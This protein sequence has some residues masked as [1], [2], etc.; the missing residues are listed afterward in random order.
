MELG[1]LG[2]LQVRR[3]GAPVSIPGAKPRAVLT[4]LGLHGGSVVSADTLFE[5]LWGEDPPR[6]AAKALQTHISSL[7]RALGDGVVV[8]EGAGWALAECDVDAAR[9]RSAARHG[10]DA[11]AAGDISQAV[12]HFEEALAL[13]RGIPELPDGRPGTSEKTRWNEGH[14]ALIEDRADALLATG[15]AA[16]IIGELETAVSEAPLRERRWAQLMLALYRAGRQGEALAA[17][18]RARTVLA[19]ELGIDPGPELRKLETA[20]VAQDS[21]LDIVVA[22]QLPSVMRAVTFLLTDIEGS[23]ATWEADADAMAVALARHDELAEQVV[24]S[25]GGRLIKTRGEG[26]ATFSV[27]ERPSAAAAAAM[28]LQ[29]AITHEQWG[30][31]APMRIRIALHTG[32][33]ELRDGDYFGRAV[34][35]AARL[36]SLAVGGQILCSGATAELV[37]DSLPDDVVLADLGM[38]QL[39]NLARPEHVFELRLETADDDRPEEVSESPL[40]RPGLP[41]V[42]TGSGPFVG[43]GRELDGLVSAWQTALAGGAHAV[44]IAGEPGVGKTRLAGE[45]SQQAYQQGAVVLYGR[46]D[47]DLGAPYQPF[48]EALRSLVPCLGSSR[49]R[50]TR[51]VEALLPLV[52]ALTDVLPDVAAP[53]RADPDT[54]RYALFDAVVALLETASAASPIVLVLDDLHWAAKPTLLL[55]RHFLRFGDHA[56][57]Q[58]VGTYRS[59]DLDRSHPLAAMLADL[60]RDG[61]S[62]RINLSGLNEDDVSAYVAKAGYDDE[63]LGRALASV[64]GGNPFFLIEALRHVDESGGSWDPS[65]LPQGVREAVSRRLSRL[66]VETNKALAAAAVVGNRFALEF[67]EQVTDQDLVDAFDEACKAGIILEEPGG[68]YRFNHA[69]V[70]QSLLAELPS[71]RR[72]RLH[73][74]IAATLETQPGADDELLAELAHHYFECAWAGNAAK[75]VEYSRRAADQAMARLGYEGAADL[76]DQ[77]L[78]ALEEIDDDLPDRDDQAAELLVAR[79]EA[80]LAAGDVTSAVGAVAQLQSATMHSGRLAAWATCFDGQLSML[81]HPERLDEAETALSAAA[82]KLAELDDA[83][84]EAKAHTVRA[85]CLARLGRIGDCEVALDDALTAARRAR[86]H[87]RVNAVLAGAPL[88]ALWGPNPVPRAGGRCLDVVRLLRITTDSPAVEATS[89]RCQ[90]VLEAFRGRDAAARRM[91][92][93]ARRTVTELGLRHALLEVEQFAGIVELV[94]ADPATAEPHLRKAYKGFRRMGLDADTAETAA[95]LGRACVALDRDAEADELCTESE[96][97]AGHALKPSIAWRTLRSQLLS[98][99]GN[100]EEARRVAQAAIALAERTDGLVDHGDACQSLATV[101]AAAGDSAG[102]RAAAERAANLYER[103]G[104]AALADR[105]RSMLD[106]RVVS[107]PSTPPEA[108]SIELDNE[109]LRVGERVMDAIH[110]QAWD[111]VEELFAPGASIESRRKV[112][113]LTMPSDAARLGVRRELEAGTA[114]IHHVMVAA[115]GERLALSRLITSSADV[116]PGAPYDE[117][118]QLYAIDD[119][120]RVALQIWFDVEDIDAAIAELDALHARFEGE[121]PPARRF[122]NAASRADERVNELFADRRW[123]EID[124]LLADDVRVDD[125]RRGLHREGADHATELANA[126]A[127]ADVGVK[128]MTSRV[129]AIRGQRLVLTRTVFSGRDQRPDAFR[130]EMLRIAEI[131]TDE[132]IV[133]LVAF[134]LDDFDSAIR[135]LDARYLVGEAAGYEHTWSIVAGA[136]AAFNRRELLATTPDWVSIDHRRGAAFADGDMIAYI[137]AA[138]DDSPDT[139]IYVGEVHRLNKVGAVVTHLARG[140]SQEDFDAEWRDVNVLAVEGDMVSRSELFNEGDLDAAI[141]TFDELSP[142][143][144]RLESAASQAVERYLAHFAARDW[145]ALAEVLAKDVAIDDRRRVVNA[146]ARHGRDAEIANLRATADAGFMHITSVVIAARGQRLILTRSAGHDR[147]SEE[148]LSDALA[149]VEISSHNQIAAIVIFDLEDFDAA[150]AE[151]DARFV[152]GEAAAYAH[153]WSVIARG[154]AALNRHE[155]PPTTP[156]CVSIDHRRG[157]AFA[158]GDLIE[159]FRA[160]W[161]LGQDIRTYVEVVHRLSELGA[162]CTHAGH[163]V[164]HEGFDAE[165]HGVDLLTVEGDMVNRCEA[166]DDADLDSALARFDE[167]HPRERRLE[168]AASQVAKR[169]LAHFAARDWDEL[170]KVLADDISNDDRRRVV[171]AGIRHGRDAEL[172]SLRAYA[173]VGVMHMGSVSMA[174]RGARLALVRASGAGGE[175]REFFNELLA[176][177][178]IN[179]HDQISAIVV[180]D[181]DDFEAA[182]AELDSRFLAGEGAANAQTWSVISGSYAAINRHEPPLTTPDCVNIDRRREIAMGV[183]D[184]IASIGAGPDPN[185]DSKVYVEAV[186]RL[187]E[188]GAVVT[189][190]AY[191]TSQ[192]G[193]DAEWRGIAVLTVDGELVNRTEV[194]DEADLDAAIASFDQL[195]RPALRLENTA[196][197]AN[198]RLIAHVS[199]REWDAAAS[200]LA[201]DHYSDDRRRITGAGTRRGRDAD[202]ENFRVVADLGANIAVEVIATRG[203]RLVLTR[204]HVELGDK[205]QPF[206][207]EFFGVVETDLDG[208]IAAV[209][210]LD[211]EDF[212]AAI[213]ELDARYLAGEAAA[214]ARTW[215]AVKDSYD[216]LNRHEIPA[217]TGDFANIDHRRVTPFAPGEVKAYARASWD[218][219]P[220]ASYRIETV[221]RLSDRGAIV[222]HAIRGTSQDGFEAEWREIHLIAVQGDLCNRSELFDEGDLDA[223]LARFDELSRSVPGL[224]NT[225][226]RVFKRLYS[227]VAAGEWHAVTQ[228][229]AENVSV[230]DR[231]RVVNAGILHGRD[232]NIKDAQA[233][234]GVGFTMTMLDVLA[235]RG[236]RI[237]LTGIRV[238]GRDPQA[239]QNDALQIMEIDAEERIARVVVFDL[240]DFDAAIAELDARYLAGE[241]MVH[242]HTWSVIS[243]V[244][245]ALSRR[246]LPSTTTDFV[247]IDHR[248]GTA[249]AAGELMEYLRAGWDVHQEV[250]PYVEAVHRLSNL[251]AVVTHSARLTSREGFEAEWRTIDIM[252]VDGDLIDRAELFDEADLDAA[253]AKFEDLTQPKPRLENAASHVTEH[254]AVHLRARDWDAMAELLADDFCSDDRRGVVGAGIQHGRDAHMADMRTIVDLWITNVSSTIIATRGERLVLMRTHF[255]GSDQGPGAFVTEVFGLVEIDTDERIVA[256]VSFDVDHIDA[257]IAELDARYLAGEAAVYARTWSVVAGAY[258]AFNRHELPAAD[259]VTVDNRRATPFSSSTMTA[260]LRA[261]WDLTPDLSIH[262]ET[263]HRLNTF[264]AVITHTGSGTSPEGFDAEWRAI[265]ILTVDGERITRCEIFDDDDDFEAALARFDELSRT[266]LQLR[267]AATRAY[268]R[269]QAQFAARDWDGLAGALAD[270]VFRDDRRRLVGAELRTGRDA[271]VAEFSAL[272]EIGVKRMT[273][274]TVAVRGGRLLLS[275]SRALGRDPRADAFRTDVLSILDLDADERI[276]AILTFDPDDL[277]AAI[278]ELDARYLAGEAAPYST[279]WSAV[280]QGY[281]ALNRHELPLM[282]PDVVT[283]DHRRGRGFAPGDLSAYLDASWELMPESTLYIA[284]VNRLNDIG[285]VVTHVVHG[286]TAEGFEAV[287]REITVLKAAGDRMSRC[288]MF[289]EEDFDAAIA[290]FNEFGPPARRLENTASQVDKRFQAC[291]GAQDWDVMAEMLSAGFSIEDRRRVVN[292]GNLHGRDAELG[293]HAYAAA[294]TQNVES[295]VIATRG[296]RVT[297]NHYR[298]SGGDQSPDAFSVEMLAVVEIDADERMAAVVVFDADDLDAALE[299]LENRYLAGEAAAHARTWT[300]IAKSFA[301]IGRQELPA[302]SPGTAFVDHRRSAAFGATD[303]SAY[304]R[305]GWDPGQNIRPHV[306]AVHRLTDLGAVYSY[307]AHGISHE[308]FDAAWQGVGLTTVDGDIVNRCEFF[309]ED[310]LAAA[311]ATFDQLGRPAPLL[312]NTA[313]RTVDRVN[314]YFAARDWAAL[315]TMMANDVVD[316][317]RRRIANA[318]I[319]QG[320]DAIV[321]GVQTAAGLGAQHITSTAIAIRGDRLAL[322]R[323]R[324]SG[325]DQGPEAFYAEALGVVEV[326]GDERVVAHVGFDLEDIDAALEELENRYLAGQAAAHAHTWSLIAGGNAAANRNETLPMTPDASMIDHRLRTTL[327]ADGLNA[328]VR[329]SRDLTPDLYTLIESVHRLSDFGVVVTHASRGTSQDDFEA[330]WRQITL[331][332]VEGDLCNRCEIFD[333]ADLDAALAR[334]DELDRTARTLENAASQV[335]KSFLAHFAAGD[336][337]AMAEILADDFFNDDRRQVVS[338]EVL[339]GR[340]AQM[341]NMRA[342]AELL[343][344]DVTSTVIA[345]RAAR[346]ALVRL[347]FS[348]RSHAPNAFQIEVL[349]V[350]GIDTEDRIA[351]F[352]VFDVDDIH[353]AF[354]ELDAR[355]LAGEASA[356]AQTWSAISQMCAAINRREVFATTDE[357]VDID[358]RSLAA[359]GSGDLKAYIGAAL[360]DGDYRIHIESVQL[361]SDLGAVVGLVS[362]GT[363][364]GGFEGE[365]RMTDIF[366]VEGDVISRCEIYDDADLD[367]ALARFEELQPQA[368]RLEH[369]VQERFLAHFAARDWD[370]MG[371]DFADDYYC[372]D[373]RRVVNAGVRHGRDAAFE[374]LRVAADIGLITNIT[375]E[376]IATRGE[377]LFLG[378]TRW[379]GP[380][381]RPEDFNT[382]IVNVIE[383]DAEE[384]IAAQ[385]LFDSND[386]GSAVEELDARYLAGEA[387]GHHKIWSLIAHAFAAIN[388]HELP[389]LTSNW[390]NIDHRRGAAFATGDMTAY[391]RD[392]WEDAPD[393]HVYVEAVHCLTDFGA[394]V[395]QAAHGT[396]RHGFEA[397][398]RE[399]A[400]FTFDGDLLSRCELFDEKDLDAA[401]AR[402]EELRPR[403]VQLENAATRTVEQFFAH[404]AVC[405]WDAMAELLADDVSADDRRPVVNAGIRRGRDAEMA[406]WRAT[407]DLWTI[408]VRSA[409]ATR[410]ERLALVRF[411]FTNKDDG[412]EAFSVA[413]LAVVGINDSN[414]ISEIVVIEADDADG[415]FAELDVRY[416]AGEAAVHA[417]TWSV[418]TRAFAGLNQHQLPS[419][420]PGWVNID[421][422]STQRVEADDLTALIRATW[423]VVP[424]GRVYIEAVHRLNDVGLAITYI[425]RGTSQ[426]GFD[427]EWRAVNISTVDGDMISRSEIFDE[428]D[429]DAALARFDELHPPT[430]RLENA[431]TQVDQRFWSHFLARNWDAMEQL[432]ADDISTEDRRRVM[433]A[434]VRHGRAGYMAEMRA[435][436]ELGTENIAATVVAIRGA[437]LALIRIRGSNNAAGVGELSVEVLNIVELD[438]E[439]RIAAKVGFDVDKIDAAFAELD[440]RYIAGEARAHARTWSVISRFNDA[441]NRHEIPATD[442]VTVDHRRLIKADASDQSALV[443]ELWNATPDLRINIETVHRLSDF[444]G[445]VTR[446]LQGTTREGFYAEWRMIQLLTV[447]GD[448]IS[449]S[450]LFDETDLDAAL[451][452]F[453]ELHPQAR[454]VENAASRVY[455]RFQAHFATRDWHAIAD[456]LTADLYSDDRRFVVGGG[457]RPGRDALIEDLRAVADVDITNATADV[458]ATRGGRLALLR[459]QFSRGHAEPDPFHVDFLQLVEINAEDR[460]TA[461]IAFDANDIDA[462]F[463]ELD[464]RYLAGEA[465]PHA[466]TWTAI[467]Q[468]QAAYNRHELPPTTADLVNID[469]RRG[470]A[471]ATGDTIPWL[472]ATYDVAPNVKGHLEAVHRLG[473]LG[474]VVTEVVTGTS[475]AGFAFEWREVAVFVF[476]GDKIC[477]FELFDETDLDAA[478]ARFD[479]LHSHP[480]RL[481]NAASQVADRY[482]KYFGARD[483]AALAET[484][485]EDV[486]SSDRR[487]VINAG[488]LRG[489][490][491]HLANMRAVAEVGFEGLTSTVIATRGQ[492][493][494]VIRIRS[495]V[496]GSASSEVTA[497]MLSMIEID[498]DNRLTVAVIFDPDDIDAAFEELDARY[499][500]GEAAAHARTWM[501]VTQVQAAYNRHE[502]LPTTEGVVNIDHRRGRAFVPGDVAPYLSATYDVAPNV[503]GYIEAVHRLSNLGVVVTAIIT[504]TS[505]EGFGFEWR[506]IA[507]FVFEGDKI[508]RFEVFDESD[509]DTALARFDEL[510]SQPTRLENA[511]SRLGERQLAH[512]AARD[513]AAMVELLADDTYTDDRRRV[514]NAGNQHG[515]DVD[516]ATMRALA[517]LGV[518]HIVSTVIATRG[519]RLALTLSRMSGR[520]Q[521]PD[522]FYTEALSILEIDADN[523]GTAKVV[524]DPD[525]ID[526][527]IAELDARYLAGEAAAHADAWSAIVRAYT[528]VNRHELPPTTPDWVNID[529]RRGRAFA[530]GDLEAYL[531]ATWDLAPNVNVYVEAVHRLSDLGGLVTHCAHGSS[532]EG[533]DAEWREVILLTFDAG[534]INHF[535]VFDEAQLDVALK[536]IDELERLS[537]PRTGAV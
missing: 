9:Y 8:T 358:H 23:T 371:Q 57:V 17:F 483:W 315:G 223:A 410:G 263:V 316:E 118:L 328:Y 496:R 147:G 155:V 528:A 282:T 89:T 378:R 272:A 308:G 304:V 383:I 37:I 52:P 22:Q 376:I 283:I 242:A 374:D 88:A 127:I 321:G 489:R 465:A 251:G 314:A 377:R 210:E 131:G 312:A 92:D 271:V 250:R 78:H 180:F 25:R 392:L 232:A 35:R 322:C 209:V 295:T 464:A 39:K 105:A 72:M 267:N 311:L 80:L 334:F 27:F 220:D 197:R 49:L 437:R 102:A 202:I 367:A 226:T 484:M 431:A 423:E 368:P 178:E 171:N 505:R 56:R 54:E 326:D 453:G 407:K 292:A 355:Y 130:T 380:D 36:R 381:Q 274:D 153:T 514:V 240:E 444:G 234:V 157:A 60:H 204:N 498:A 449:R 426:A 288:E 285:A 46:C 491:A 169:Y 248:K 276:A 523:R 317:D 331:F 470:I 225:A 99:S 425:A 350:V 324:Y 455:E 259:W 422:R 362:N 4:M 2:P 535:E 76:Y 227:H 320:R 280:I 516:I 238:S 427:A 30:L 196:S 479:E 335:A 372:D 439:N 32:E 409:V 534:R 417:R 318:G 186:H 244:F 114:R 168:N 432:L 412:P 192:G 415:A 313:T 86:D 474:V 382:E 345:T 156:D 310:D 390:V 53:T 59:T 136:Y 140:I 224:E 12:A 31:R 94:L 405:D 87:R 478:L 481:E 524:F 366:M 33:V 281:M 348:D 518:A 48:T 170:A 200:I 262:I 482:W 517:D 503:T 388:R 24:T 117:L 141:A 164:S 47:E 18:K 394:V 166:F 341:A 458:L 393:I 506:E 429:L 173:D 217:T 403:T 400:I 45:W 364:Q 111:E 184:L 466:H 265:D 179:S 404:F 287:W 199:A 460:I 309:D 420:T 401:L 41:A 365:W 165:W 384:R 146:G 98:R 82:N 211:L 440:A 303:L 300:V 91:I 296:Q 467:A 494:T 185:Q 151:L 370:A 330:E 291:F 289:D 247:D 175:S 115:R 512:F 457:I 123:D 221:H 533:V 183:G 325:R 359:V 177:V 11:A 255:S 152:A 508:C 68:R 103:K 116:D 532:R 344:T 290:A 150:I 413:A 219:M 286:S 44:L 451:A 471:F 85:S 461:F 6:T 428:A 100:H 14:A 135:E 235:A 351:A 51:G 20:I 387:A 509:L 167:L 159:Y 112:V 233:T 536:R 121:R 443:R 137:H 122:E 391:I 70:R 176:V 253:L 530:P 106:E 434:G 249:F 65:T 144:P 298:F 254:F 58:I 487:R 213:A 445:V 340:D 246:E 218:Q 529:H 79:C 278:T 93:S 406:N 138:W 338:G 448:R 385:V 264:G 50:A 190:A 424:H 337:D 120:G 397:E 245:T 256:I 520:D 43:R 188:R 3:D 327:D 352:V 525:D 161:E 119:D 305:A 495:S 501:A 205:Q 108:P 84:G 537:N 463:A 332:T 158:P 77:A 228:M 113:G 511:A 369:P 452:R 299:E 193:F 29:D 497:E 297:L 34:N 531:Q 521:R 419:T 499:L 477:R 416:L 162:V 389:E 279:V 454:P 208:R 480:T 241:A 181:R 277:D 143:A 468:V 293:V 421:H 526:A 357:F 373:R 418:I 139:E 19:D 231:R 61:T 323:L 206:L 472:R 462:A 450:E 492:H 519:E 433:N 339:H 361:L 74:R 149:V 301:S 189:Y 302:I 133:A 266:T 142:P 243:G 500:A 62:N 230:D 96:R 236:E 126:R 269:M 207:A 7:R 430:P 438:A 145:D 414:R 154:H 329:A 252:T 349:G 268:E 488:D 187:A 446:E 441:F 333:E 201:D 261:M 473:N 95:L 306:Q 336:W 214:H 507:L 15:R 66:P 132:R 215:S 81:I 342:I 398:W 134:D 513:W 216:A 475:Q 239:I 490:A 504:G 379:L 284:D 459:A 435:V 1:V 75:A 411:V 83:A 347:G 476:E 97:L 273:F 55:L 222:T 502:A 442:W 229:T 71:V 395:S 194:F 148:F 527:A 456:M 73:Q 195:S 182:V 16:E 399:N 64:T 10:R 104:A 270:D 203:S 38:R 163:G 485:A 510:H 110:R 21:A 260:S 294:G 447:E 40:E 486:D 67:V 363:S 90:A 63:E 69:L 408:S 5:L 160:G 354:A 515:R 124:A 174:A 13:W 493:L 129:L 360:S 319:R 402:F 436:A 172:A 107:P 353:A 343:S 522:A 469:H 237:A 375:S 386:I 396:S 128:N 346:L 257:A 125:R 109:A 198:A 191:E 101:L 28:E 258:A 275:R 307:A 26:D 42:L 212:D 356:H